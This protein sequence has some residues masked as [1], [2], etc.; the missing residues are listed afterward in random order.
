MVRREPVVVGGRPLQQPR[1]QVVGRVAGLCVALPGADDHVLPHN[2]PPLVAQHRRGR[3]RDG[4]G[5]AQVGVARAL[6]LR[7]DAGHEARDAP[8]LEHVVHDADRRGKVDHAG[9]APGGDGAQRHRGPG[10]VGGGQG[11]PVGANGPRP[12]LE[13]QHLGDEAAFEAPRVFAT[14]RFED[15]H[16]REG[17]LIQI[18][19]R[20]LG[21][22]RLAAWAWLK[23]AWPR[24]KAAWPRQKAA[25]PRQKAAWPRQKAAYSRDKN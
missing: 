17:G 4:A 6:E 24:L 2:T 23:A 19:C 7:G 10:L 9:D 14:G 13:A 5:A 16:I 20:G 8:G 11:T 12:V 21:N 25:W 18:R 22:G 3:R 15:T 1:R